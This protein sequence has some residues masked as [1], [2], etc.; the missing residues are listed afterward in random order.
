MLSGA[1]GGNKPHRAQEAYIAG[2]TMG[3]RVKVSP[4][5]VKSLGEREKLA[6]G[7]TEQEKVLYIRQNPEA[8][9]WNWSRM[10]RN[11]ELYV[12]GWVRHPDHKTIILHDWHRVVV[13]REVR[14][15]NVT[16]LD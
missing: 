3:Y 16:F 1:R 5:M 14:G 15:R 13:N 2:G 10:T 9:K 11:P 7:L 8:R 6:S 4:K 12:R